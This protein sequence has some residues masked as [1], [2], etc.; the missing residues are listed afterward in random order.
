MKVQNHRREM[1][2]EMAVVV[3]KEGQGQCLENHFDLAQILRGDDDPVGGRDRPQTRYGDLT[4]HNQDRRPGQKKLMF[5]EK[6]K[7]C[8]HQDLV[9]DGIQELAERGDHVEPA[10]DISVE[11]VR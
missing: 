9:R 10:G 1:Q 5:H 8:R 2:L 7:A 4:R 11:Q 6:E 3:E